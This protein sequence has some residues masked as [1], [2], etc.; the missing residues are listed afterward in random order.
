[1]Q[2]WATGAPRR[3][4]TLKRLSYTRTGMDHPAVRANDVADG[5]THP[6]IHPPTWLL[7]PHSPKN[8]RENAC[9]ARNRHRAAHSALEARDREGRRGKEAR[10]LQ[11]PC[12]AVRRT[13][14]EEVCHCAASV[15]PQLMWKGAPAQLTVSAAKALPTQRSKQ[16]QRIATPARV[17]GR[18]CL[19]R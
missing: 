15:A 16:P 4:R 2:Q 8:T 1:M 19:Q 6:P 12:E 18:A 3:P 10:K 9:R 7:S 5:S 17:A 13:L 14:L 11:R